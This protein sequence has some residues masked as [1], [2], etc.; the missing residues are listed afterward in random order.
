[1][2][3]LLAI[4]ALAAG[5]VL[6]VTGSESLVRGAAHIA[7]LLGLRPFVIG[8]TI[9]AFGTSTP[10]LF[11]SIAFALNQQ[12]EAAVTNVI[13]SNIANVGLILG[14][15]ALVR[16]IPV[17]RSVLRRDLPLMLGISALA[18]LVFLDYRVS[19]LEGAFLAAGIVA[20]V[21]MSYRWGRSD[22]EA[23]RHE[24]EREHEH[25][26]DLEQEEK[27]GNAWLNV[28]L[29]VLGLVGLSLGGRLVVMGAS[30]LALSLGV[31]P[32]VVS[33][34]MVALGTSLPELAACLAAAR[35]REPEIVLGNVLGSNVF[36]L[37]AVLGGA[38]L[39]RPLF[40]PND[41][42][43]HVGVMLGFSFGGALLLGPR[44]RLG[45]IG[46]GALLAAYLAYVILVYVLEKAPA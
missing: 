15:T 40:A 28:L 37:L 29:I 13:G 1:M 26:L 23:I 44:R 25:G 20:Y 31:A 11:A 12:T 39:V 32:E 5:V 9:V 38:S 34:T 43:T 6:L 16:P 2:S 4:L 19:R 33:L 7:R 3:V 46:G 17:E 14:F 30:S 10:E 36:N 45:R 42:W 8:V 27:P 18:S 22:P 24:L 35:R 41:I 21:A